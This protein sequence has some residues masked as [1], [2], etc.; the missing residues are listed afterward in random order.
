MPQAITA[1]YENGVFIPKGKVHLPEHTTVKISVP[2]V[3]PRKKKPVSIEALFDIA[4]GGTETDISVNHD[5]YLYGES[6]R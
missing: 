1:I 5:K 2:T 6:P 4:A 3:S